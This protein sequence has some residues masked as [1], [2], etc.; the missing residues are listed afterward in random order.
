MNY[1][2]THL[3]KLAHIQILTPRGKNEHVEKIRSDSSING[4]PSATAMCE[5]HYISKP[6]CKIMKVKLGAMFHFK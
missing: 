3:K 6:K 1:C 5:L 2:F 4:P